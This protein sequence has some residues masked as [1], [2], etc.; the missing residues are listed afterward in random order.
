MPWGF[1]VL[2]FD[3]K[4]GGMRVLVGGVAKVEGGIFGDVT[5]RQTCD[6]VPFF[7]CAG[8]VDG[9]E[10]YHSILMLFKPPPTKIPHRLICGGKYHRF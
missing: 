8:E 2:K 3:A 6:G 9:S 1:C 7:F 4:C 10:V 5:L